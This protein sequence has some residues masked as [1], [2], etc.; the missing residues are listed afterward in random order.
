MK[1]ILII[2]LYFFISCQNDDCKCDVNAEIISKNDSIINAITNSPRR[3]F[4]DYWKRFDEPSL[5][6]VQKESYR[7]SITVLLNDYYKVYRV[8][9]S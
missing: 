1:K 2:F 3:N 5:Q 4:T 9:G 8:N 6:S 7:F